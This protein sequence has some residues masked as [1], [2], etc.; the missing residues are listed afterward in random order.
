MT[1]AAAN[2]AIVPGLD[3]STVKVHRRGN[4]PSLVMLHCLGV[5]HGLWDIAAAG[6]EEK[7]TLVSYDFPG[8]G[9]TPVPVGSYLIEDLSRQLAG[10]LDRDHFRFDEVQLATQHLLDLDVELFELLHVAGPEQHV[11][12]PLQGAEGIERLVDLVHRAL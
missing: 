7:L 6:L 4:G 3:A 10:V 2:A 12:A 11:D 5:D 8:H 9:E 1:A